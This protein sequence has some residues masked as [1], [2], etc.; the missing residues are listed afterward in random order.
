MSRETVLVTGASAGIGRELARCFAAD[1][2]ALVLV[3][4]RGDELEALAAELTREHGV[5]ARIMATDLAYYNTPAE[6]A[7]LLAADGIAVDVLVNNAGFGA[8]GELTELEPARLLA[9]LQV[10]V[11]ALTHLTRLL[12]PG[13]LARRRGGVLNVASTAAFQPGPGMAVYYATKAYVL[14]FSGALTEELRG[15]GVTATC[16]APGATATEFAAVAGL[17]RS[18][19]FRAGVMRADVVARAGHAGF[20]R[21]RA[22]VVPGWKNRV[23]AALVPLAPRA[24]VRRLVRGLNR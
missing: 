7:G 6:I 2:A 13:M 19:L 24:A 3:A 21:G 8:R 23:G 20:R 16:L 15:T 4:R 5:P 10:N 11:T 18:R 12:L 22:L 17:T 9:M 14:S 1:G